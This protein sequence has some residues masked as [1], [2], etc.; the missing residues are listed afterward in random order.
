MTESLKVN[1]CS[2]DADFLTIGDPDKAGEAEIRI[3]ESREGASIYVTEEKAA[4]I[5]NHLIKVFEI[6][7]EQR[8]K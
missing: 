2:I 1:C 5:V 8:N 6:T 3:V 7:P 4:Q